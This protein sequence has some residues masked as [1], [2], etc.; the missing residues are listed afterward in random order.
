MLNYILVNT[1]LV[2]IILIF[3]LLIATG[4]IFYKFYFFNRLW[5]DLKRD[6]INEIK[7]ILEIQI[8]NK[9]RSDD[10]FKIMDEKLETRRKELEKYLSIL[11]TISSISPLLGLLGTVLGMIEST[12]GILTI[13]NDL[14]LKGIANALIT[15]AMGLVIAIP[16]IVFYNFFIEKIDKYIK[17]VKDKI[18]SYMEI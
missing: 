13:D 4:I 17:E 3:N 18:I 15:T 1:G 2:G 10:F 16:A 14:L 11:A 6:L 7:N 9:N 12:R 8:K 5:P